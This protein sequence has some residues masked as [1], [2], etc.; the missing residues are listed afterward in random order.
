M[1]AAS[2][3]L[4]P[5]PRASGPAR[6]GGAARALS[7]PIPDPLWGG[8]RGSPCPGPCPV[9]CPAP[10]GRM[11]GAG[12]L[13]LLLSITGEVGACPDGVTRP[14]GKPCPLPGRGREESSNLLSGADKQAGGWFLFVFAGFPPPQVS[15]LDPAGG[16]RRGRVP[17]PEHPPAPPPAGALLLW[18][19]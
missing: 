9:P 14:E 7:L 15:S 16:R 3:Q 17:D 18:L 12:L 19:V 8:G 10:P 1:S 13:L 6:P 2:R 4:P 11:A 5:P